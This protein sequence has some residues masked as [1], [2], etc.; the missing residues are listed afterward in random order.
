MMI[1]G[2]VLKPED[3]IHDLVDI[4]DAVSGFREE[5]PRE[6]RDCMTRS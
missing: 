5:A 1:E 4:L 2:R 3:R 6:R